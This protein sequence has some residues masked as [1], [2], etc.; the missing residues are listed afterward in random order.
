[1]GWLIDKALHEQIGG[2]PGPWH[3]YVKT[4]WQAASDPAKRLPSVSRGRYS[5][6]DKHHD[7][8]A[9]AQNIA[10]YAPVFQLLHFG[11]GW[12]DVAAGLARWRAQG[13]PPFD[14]V[15]GVVHRWWGEDGVL[16]VLAWAAWRD[17]EGYSGIPGSNLLAQRAHL[18]GLPK[19]PPAP[20]LFADGSVA[21]RLANPELWALW[22]GDPDGNHI[23]FHI[24]VAEDDHDWNDE[25]LIKGMGGGALILNRY[26]GWYGHLCDGFEHGTGPV[27]VVIRPIGHLGTFYRSP[28][29]GL[30]HR[31]SE[32]IHY[33]GHSQ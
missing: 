16:D 26:A 19:A 6:A 2:D 15:L 7:E 4:L 23:G 5:T 13:Y 3:R 11:L 12:T 8:A 14:P 10:Y 22:Q 32:E 20:D 1:M 25:T 29:T 24:A 9:H 17:Q 21:R 18:R 33:M 30:W 27:D 31:T 28:V